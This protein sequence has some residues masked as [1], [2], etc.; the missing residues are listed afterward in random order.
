MA[1]LQDL[2]KE[3]INVKYDNF[4]S[5]FILHLHLTHIDLSI[6]FLTSFRA[7]LIST[8]RTFNQPLHIDHK[9]QPM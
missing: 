3:R 7:M 5:V 4:D 9:Y 6:D 2:Q 1:R 8:T